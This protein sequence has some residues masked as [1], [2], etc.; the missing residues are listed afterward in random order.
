MTRVDH[1]DAHVGGGRVQALFERLE[2]QARP[3]HMQR[4]L[5]RVARVVQDEQR[6]VVGV[7]R[8]VPLN[9]TLDRPQGVEHLV[10]GRAVQAHDVRVGDVPQP[11]EHV[12]D[13]ARVTLRIPKLDLIG[14]SDVIPH[15]HGIPL[16]LADGERVRREPQE[17]DE[18]PP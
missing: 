4:S 2:R 13:A 10:R 8:L 3:A 14:L 12:R 5:V 1:D 6:L 16:H 15:D 17:G 7:S 18:R 9:P 11:L